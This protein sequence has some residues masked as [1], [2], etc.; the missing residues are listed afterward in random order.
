MRHLRAYS[1]FF[2][3]VTVLFASESRSEIEGSTFGVENYGTY[4]LCCST[5][6]DLTY[7]KNEAAWVRDGLVAVGYTQV[8]LSQDSAVDGQDWTDW[9]TPNVWGADDFDP[10][11]TDWADVAFYAGHGIRFC[12][13][14]MGPCADSG[15]SRPERSLCLAN[16][17]QPQCSLAAASTE[18]LWRGTSWL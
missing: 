2:F 6:A 7:T 11:G 16:G 3:L 8:Q 12:G 18:S 9:R 17:S 15:G 5:C 10:T 1:A 14:N 4:P 13:D